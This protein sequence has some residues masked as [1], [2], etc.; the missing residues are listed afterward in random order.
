MEEP[1]KT[2]ILII[3]RLFTLNILWERKLQTC[4]AASHQGAIEMFHLRLPCCLSLHAVRNFK[5]RKNKHL[6][7]IQPPIDYPRERFL[8]PQVSLPPPSPPPSPPCSQPATVWGPLVYLF[9]TLRHH[10]HHLPCLSLM[11][12]CASV[13]CLLPCLCQCDVGLTPGGGK[14]R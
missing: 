7:T 9:V 14:Q 11:N 10:S 8:H 2:E 1:K 6:Q 5:K 12:G 4:T 13:P 3:W